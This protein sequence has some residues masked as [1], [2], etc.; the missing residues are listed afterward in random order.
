LSGIELKLD[1][2]G[3]EAEAKVLLGEAR[4]TSEALGE[5]KAELS[6]VGLE[7][8]ACAGEIEK[9]EELLEGLGSD[10]EARSTQDDPLSRA[11]R[12]L[13]AAKEYLGR[14]RNA[15]TELLSTSVR[16]AFNTLSR[17]G[18][19]LSGL[20]LAP[21]DGAIDKLISNKGEEIVPTSLSEGEKQ[22]L[23][24]SYLWGLLSC[25]GREFPIV[26]DTPFGRLDSAHRRL[27]VEEFLV[28]DLSQVVLLV[29]D[30]EANERFESVVN[31][32]VAR[33][34]HLDHEDGISSIREIP[35]SSSF[36]EAALVC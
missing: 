26:I 12:A 34:Y 5:A 20:S 18:E 24:L 4:Q 9:L 33:R 28:K 14:L 16:D 10:L 8:A 27:I 29:T 32:Y 36:K 35:I 11:R 30:E 3:D 1:Q 23:A 7:R 31:G 13:R 19:V 25:D 6:Q 15:K 21:E 2:M 17:K 22:V